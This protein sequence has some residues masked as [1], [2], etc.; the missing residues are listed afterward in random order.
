MYKKNFSIPK[1]IDDNRIY[2]M[3]I[4][5][6]VLMSSIA[7][8]FLNLFNMASILKA[9]AL[10]AIVA[11]GFST[12]MIS[13]YLDLSI[14]SVINLGAVIVIL[15]SNLAG[16]ALGIIV[17]VAAGLIVG[18]INGLFVTKGKIHSF[19]VTLGM[20][21]TVKGFLYI[22]TGSGSINI[23]SFDVVFFMESKVLWIF[24]PKV[25]ITLI[26]ILVIHFILI[27]TRNGR[28]FFLMGGNKETAW[29]A[30]YNTDRYAIIA[31]MISSGLAAVG[32][33]LFALSSGAAIPNM[34]EKGI[35]PQL[36]VIAATIIGG[37]SM[38]GGKG[39]VIKSSFA[40]LT[41]TTLFNG[42]GCLGSGYEVQV[43]AAGLILAI[44]VLYDAYNTYKAD[45][46]RG[47]RL[48]LL[49]KK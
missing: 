5:V 28:V 37:T 36:L 10:C 32:G 40:V 18:V 4:V 46:L 1:F 11:A 38:Q 3:F 12:A 43:A 25:L 39:S 20:L 22:L 8:N 9:S 14:G 30:G 29:I 31:F 48:D 27:K 33:I 23:K 15:V 34:G 17:A 45:L 42:L 41:L 2:L 26:L 44:I 6:F 13:G 16:L 19:I 24:T 47:Q 35:N 21:T 49:M 7:P